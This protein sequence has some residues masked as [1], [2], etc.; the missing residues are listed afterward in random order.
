MFCGEEERLTDWAIE[1]NRVTKT[2]R[3][4]KGRM[5]VI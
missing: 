5:P 1:E 3:G 2:R 4:R